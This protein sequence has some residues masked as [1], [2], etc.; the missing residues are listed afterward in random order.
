MWK[1]GLALAIDA[2]R[3]RGHACN[4]KPTKHG[5]WGAGESGIEARLGAPP[6]RRGVIRSPKH[7]TRNEGRKTGINKQPETRKM[8]NREQHFT[9]TRCIKKQLE[10][11]NTPS[12]ATKAP[13]G[14]ARNAAD[15]AAGPS[16]AAS[17]WASS[18]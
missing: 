7:T 9:A 8:P 15:G 1:Q 11:S 17:Q 13:G 12:R 14:R 10:T 6:A 4:K 18:P 5:E 3:G 2:L 16:R